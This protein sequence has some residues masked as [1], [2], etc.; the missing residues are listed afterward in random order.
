MQGA[1]SGAGPK[2]ARDGCESAGSLS[3]TRC[4][5]AKYCSVACQK[6]AWTDHKAACKNAARTDSASVP[7]HSRG[8]VSTS[9]TTNFASAGSKASKTYSSAGFAGSDDSLAFNGFDRV[10]LEKA[11]AGDADASLMLGLQLSSPI[12]SRTSEEM[13]TATNL[14]FTAAHAGKAAAW[15]RLGL[16]AEVRSS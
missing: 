1:R 5:S 15:K 16:L 14:L 3:C 10:L 11:V 9:A 2:C 4:K 8:G 13:S 7:A 6:I 12:H